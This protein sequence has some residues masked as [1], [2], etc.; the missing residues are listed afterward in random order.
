MDSFFKIV[1][2]TFFL[3]YFLKILYH[4]FLRYSANQELKLGPG[5]WVD[6]IY[7]KAIPRPFDKRFN[8]PTLIFNIIHYI[9]MWGVCICF[10]TMLARGVLNKLNN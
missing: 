1:F 3:L 7:F 10:L 5:N 2:S 8:L 9:V 6:Y 4:V